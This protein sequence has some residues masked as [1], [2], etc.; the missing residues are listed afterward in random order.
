MLMLSVPLDTPALVPWWKK[1]ETTFE[2]LAIHVTAETARHAGHVDILREMIDGSAGLNPTNSNLP[3]WDESGWSTYY[4]HVES[5]AR[6][7]Q[8]TFDA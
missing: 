8:S 4:Q 2:H 1:Q 3:E 5:Q 7:A 6:L